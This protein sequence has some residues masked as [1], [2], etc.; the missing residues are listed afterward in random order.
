M[1]PVCV[2]CGEQTDNVVYDVEEKCYLC[3]SCYA[4]GMLELLL[5]KVISKFH[6]DVK[7]RHLHF[8]E[9][10]KQKMLLQLEINTR[11]AALKKFSDLQKEQ[12]K[13]GLLT[14]PTPPS[15]PQG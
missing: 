4:S 14:A 15:T 8:L 10:A 3:M 2:E 9:D 13:K 6:D 7:K 5:P 1:M 12:I 11:G